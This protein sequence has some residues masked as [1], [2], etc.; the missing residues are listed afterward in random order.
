[1]R[2]SVFLKK[3]LSSIIQ[4]MN[5]TPW[6]FVR[7]PQRDF[8]RVRKWSFGETLRFLISM[9]GKA[10][11]D[12][13]LEYFDY[14]PDTPTNSSFNQRRAQILPEAFEY[15]F[16]EFT[17]TASK[18]ELVRGYRLLACD[19]SDF[20][21]SHNPEDKTTYF[22][23][24]PGTK[25]FNQIHL[26]AL[27]DL[28]ARTYADAIIQPARLE[29][30]NKAVCEMIDR[31]QG[32]VKTVFIADRGYESYN[33]FAHVQEKG[34]FFLVRVKDILRKGGIVQSLL[35]KLPVDQDSF[36][37]TLTITLTRK[38][39]KLI[40]DNPDKYRFIPQNV[41]FDY[42]DLESR[43]FYEM[44]FRIIRFPIAPDSFECIITNL[45]REDFSLDDV[46]E[47]YHMRWGIETSFRELKYAIGLIN[48]HSKKLDFIRQ[49]I[50]ARLI[51]YNFCE[52]ITTRSLPCKSNRKN[53]HTYQ[54]NYTRAI[55]ICRYFL[56]IRKGAPPDVETLIG[57][58][59]LP[60]R[61]GRSD[62]RKVKFQ[63]A[64]SFLYRIA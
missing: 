26:N 23:S 17:R 62:P 15:I 37:E 43:L 47:L 18:K 55:H 20:G 40:K 54:L 30:E 53:K 52:A 22:Q 35:Y 50:W 39:T 63:S 10:V 56:T 61:P 25:G 60:V 45:P 41:H 33:I 36:D 8:S 46:K 49:E 34:M 13:L 59:L 57:R 29:N 1:M 44:N 31:Y 12:E 21:I 4:E 48:F 14:S 38:Q 24:L 28:R 16:H 27:Y 7:D 42:L 32:E 11:K 9:E 51:L 64:V 2:Y 5:K 3:T 19:G 6:L 58:E